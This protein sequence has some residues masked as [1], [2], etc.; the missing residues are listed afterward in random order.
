MVFASGCMDGAQSLDAPASPVKEGLTVGTRAAWIVMFI[1]RA[2]NTSPLSL[3]LFLSSTEAFDISDPAFLQGGERK[4]D[5]G[6]KL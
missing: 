2:K 3:F 4:R 1:L 6:G 5:S